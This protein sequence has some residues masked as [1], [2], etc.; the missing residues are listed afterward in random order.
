MRPEAVVS[1]Q[2][3]DLIVHAG[4]IGDPSVL[5][6]LGRIAPVFAVRGN[7][8]N[9]EWAETLP[10]SR[11]VRAGDLSLFVLH[12]VAE[13][14]DVARSSGGRK[15]A[16]VIAGHSH[17]PLVQERGGVLFINPGSAGPRRFRLPVTVACLS[18]S[19]GGLTCSIITLPIELPSVLETN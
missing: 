14:E 1:L 17:R 4:D 12:D 18:I 11:I 13:L 7:N 9:G 2:G 15:W 19:N 10:G 5:E 3:S 8:D 6:S 16:A